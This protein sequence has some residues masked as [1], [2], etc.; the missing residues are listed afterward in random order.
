MSCM[1]VCPG[2]VDI[3]EALGCHTLRQMG[4]QCV[5]QKLLQGSVSPE[6]TAYLSDFDLFLNS[7]KW[8]FFQKYVHQITLNH[9][10]L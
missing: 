3:S 6:L 5:S 8:P 10:V 4:S 2:G 7:V 1:E 9:T